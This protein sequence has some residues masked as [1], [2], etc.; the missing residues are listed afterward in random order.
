MEYPF[1]L[2]IDTLHITQSDGH[3]RRR[4]R[5]EDTRHAKHQS[6]SHIVRTTHGEL[7]TAFH[8][9]R[10]SPHRSF[11]VAFCFSLFFVFFRPC[12]ARPRRAICPV[13]CIWSPASDYNNHGAGRRSSGKSFRMHTHVL[14]CVF[15][16]FVCQNRCVL[17]A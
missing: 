14:F 11:Y 10:V 15:C 4:R 17:C 3:A 5:R 7:H 2:L 13:E 8:A 6:P 9:H 12:G 1:P 16:W